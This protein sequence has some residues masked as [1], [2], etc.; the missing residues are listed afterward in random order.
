MMGPAPDGVYLMMGNQLVEL[1][2]PQEKSAD[3]A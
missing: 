1:I 2:D 3:R